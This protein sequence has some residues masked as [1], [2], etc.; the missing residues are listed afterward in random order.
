MINKSLGDAMK[1]SFKQELAFMERLEK[2]E[3]LLSNIYYIT[4]TGPTSFARLL[5]VQMPI[6]QRIDYFG[7]TDEQKTKYHAMGSE[8]RRK[9]HDSPTTYWGA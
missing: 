4:Q 9:F 5:L 8:E 6:R 1:D 3:N 2:L 7:L